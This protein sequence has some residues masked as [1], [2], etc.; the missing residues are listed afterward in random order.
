MHYHVLD[1]LSG[2]LLLETLFGM[3]RRMMIGAIVDP[4]T[5]VIA[6]VLTALE[7]TVLRSTM[8]FRDTLVAKLRDGR[9]MTSS[10][11]EQQRRVWAASSASSMYIEIVS[12]ILCRVLFVVF[13]HHR[14]VVNFGYTSSAMTGVAPMVIAAFGEIVF[15]VIVDAFAVDVE[16]RNGVDLGEFWSMH[17]RN[18]GMYG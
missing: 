11:L 10:E 13:Y 14:F 1:K 17:R 9:D 7:E 16:S 6:I 4:R 12:I 18:P 2:A 15:E 8:V 3:Y 5:H